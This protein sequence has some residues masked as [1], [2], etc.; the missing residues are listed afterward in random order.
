[1]GNNNSDPRYLTQKE[2]ITR[3]RCK[4]TKLHELRKAHDFPKP[5][6]LSP[7]SRPLWCE[8][9]IRDFE[10]ARRARNGAQPPNDPSPDDILRTL[11][12]PPREGHTKG[13]R[14]RAFWGQDLH[15]QGDAEKR[16]RCHRPIRFDLT[17]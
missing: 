2:L 7:N 5:F 9:D 13:N 3:L 12:R 11:G 17:P 15:G 1:M 14:E 4:R 16:G 8:S 6:Y 10:N